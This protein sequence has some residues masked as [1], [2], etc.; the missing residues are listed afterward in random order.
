MSKR[1]LIAVADG[2]EDLECVT[3]IDVLRRAEIEVVLASA[4]DRRMITCARGTRLTA[5]A[6]LLDVLAQDFDLIVLP[7]G[8]PGAQRLADFEPLAER[9][10]KQAK[11]GELFA[12]ICA[13]PAVALQHYGVLRQRRMTCYPSFSDRLSGCSFVDEPVVVDGNCITSQGPGTALAF[14][15]TLVE[16]LVGRS[17]R[18]EVAKAMLV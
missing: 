7:G 3:L 10:R 5:D 6:M 1:A 15:L 4:E 12:A 11:A 14:A 9:V 2:S 13:A 17:T 16:Q 18:N 8:M